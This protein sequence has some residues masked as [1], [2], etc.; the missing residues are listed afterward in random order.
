MTSQAM[1]EQKK[2][3]NFHRQYHRMYFAA[4]DMDFVFQWMM[5][6]AVHGGAGIGESFHAASRIKDGDPDS[7][8]REWTALAGRVR[9][10]AEGMARAGHTVS[11]RETFLRAAIY[12]RVVLTSMLPTVGTR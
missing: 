9:A 4:N 6:S 11:A 10:R 8:G 1:K 12:Y 7:W 2:K 5:G 3:M